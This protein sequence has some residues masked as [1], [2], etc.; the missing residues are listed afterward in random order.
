VIPTISQ[1]YISYLRWKTYFWFFSTIVFLIATPLLV[2]LAFLPFYGT[3]H[4]NIN[5][6]WWDGGGDKESPWFKWEKNDKLPELKNT[7]WL[8]G[9]TIFYFSWPLFIMF[10]YLL[11]RSEKIQNFT[12]D[13][14][15]SITKLKQEYRK[16]CYFFLVVWLLPLILFFLYKLWKKKSS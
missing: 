13:M 1:K 10:N 11:R 15:I 3:Y 5:F 7:M 9:A 12:P 6:S 16:H 14:L 8:M 4:I 2:F